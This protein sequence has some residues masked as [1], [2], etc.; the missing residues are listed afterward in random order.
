MA[1]FEAPGPLRPPLDI[2]SPV[3]MRYLVIVSFK[4]AMMHM[5]VGVCTRRYH[6]VTYPHK[7]RDVTSGLSHR[8]L[9]ERSLIIFQALGD[10][11]IPKEYH[12][13]LCLRKLSL[14]F[15][16]KSLR[17]FAERYPIPNVSACAPMD[18]KH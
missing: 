15:K 12:R 3:P 6:F 9:L 4:N 13:G 16:S 7:I 2:I 8:C 1:T 18:D 5:T 14:T 11:K 17:K 10:Q